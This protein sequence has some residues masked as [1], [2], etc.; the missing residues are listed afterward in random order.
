MNKRLLHF[1]LL[2]FIAC[3]LFAQSGCK[4][5]ETP[6]P[7]QSP[8]LPQ[9]KLVFAGDYLA[10]GDECDSLRTYSISY[11]ILDHTEFR[12]HD[13]SI[14]ILPGMPSNLNACDCDSLVYCVTLSFPISQTF[15]IGF[16]NINQPVDN[17]V[18]TVNG[19]GGYTGHTDP[20]LPSNTPMFQCHRVCATQVPDRPLYFDLSPVLPAGYNL[21]NAVIDVEGICI[22]GNVDDTSDPIEP[23]PST[24]PV[25]GSYVPLVFP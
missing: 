21:A 13:L 12:G 14:K 9:G 11:E 1:P 3:A 7:P 16:E 22:I 5:P 4:G 10:D 15:E 6:R 17:E 8:P 19:F 20:R 18:L 25:C 23:A 2:L 24:G